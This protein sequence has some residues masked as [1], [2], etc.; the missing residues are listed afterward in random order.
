MGQQAQRDTPWLGVLAAVGTTG[1]PDGRQAALG[2][3]D[4]QTL[5]A[6]ALANVE[7]VQLRP[8]AGLEAPGEQLPAQLDVASHA[9]GQGRL[10]RVEVP[11]RHPR[12]AVRVNGQNSALVIHP[13]PGCVLPRVLS[14]RRPGETGHRQGGSQA[15]HDPLS[16]DHSY[17]EPAET[18]QRAV[19]VGQT[20]VP[21]RH[22]A[23]GLAP[24]FGSPFPEYPRLPV[25]PGGQL[26]PALERGAGRGGSD[27][28]PLAVDPPAIHHVVASPVVRVPGGG[29]R[30]I[31]SGRNG[32]P[33]LAP[34]SIGNHFDC[35]G[36]LLR[37]YAP[38]Q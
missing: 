6:V 34:M 36:C 8:P 30:T 28:A 10:G 17:V 37:S 35:T 19:A 20:G 13:D 9:S 27:G 25:A 12:P 16:V 5:H 24:V 18:V 26:R 31:G 23:V 2:R 7:G 14:L 15:M 11:V 32:W 33:P 4:A 38:R 29:D 22:A 21:V 1:S 3:R